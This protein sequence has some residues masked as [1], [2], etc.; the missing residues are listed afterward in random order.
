[1]QREYDALRILAEAK[2]PCSV[3]CLWGWGSCAEHGH[4]EVLLTCEIP[5]ASSLK[6]H[7]G[8]G[9]QRLRPRQWFPLSDALRRMHESGVYHGALWPKN[10]LVRREGAD[11]YGFYLIDLARSLLFPRSILGT[12]MARFDL[13]SLLYSLERADPQFEP[14]PLLERYGCSPAGT[15]A[16]VAQSRRYRSSRHLRNRLALAFQFRALLARVF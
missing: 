6:Q 10:I 11:E 8:A 5:A 3:P 15:E 16:I 13:L 9:G 4:F 14:G 7:L 1:V 12:T 2:I